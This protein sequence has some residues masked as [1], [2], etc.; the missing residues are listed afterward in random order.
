LIVDRNFV[1]WLLK[2]PKESD[3]VRARH[4]TQNQIIKLEDI[5][6]VNNEATF[7]DLE[8][9][10][11]DEEPQHV[12]LRYEDGYQYDS[13]FGPLIKLEAEYDRRLKESQ[14]HENIEVR[15]DIG[16]NKRIVAYFTLPDAVDSDLRLMQGDELKIKYIG[17][18]HKPWN[19][20]GNVVKVPDNFGDEIGIELKTRWSHG[21]P[22]DCTNHFAI[23]FV[24][25]ATSF[26]RMSAALNK[27]SIDDK[28]VSNYIYHKL[29]GHAVDDP[30]FRVNL[31]K[32][33][34]GNNLPE[35]NRSQVSRVFCISHLFFVPICCTK[36]RRM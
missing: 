8:K 23:E 14:T 6:K 11:I 32:N 7:Q 36:V 26:D 5:W 2:Q 35:L 13:V 10:G 17:E 18:K 19:G 12:L 9:P 31:P 20:L 29:L 22:L 1:P 4:L 24:W 34:S 21:A 33:F 16:L 28:A 27:F 25:K 15:W 30:T 3:L